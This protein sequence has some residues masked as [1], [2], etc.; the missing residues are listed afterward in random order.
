MHVRPPS[1]VYVKPAKDRFD[2]VFQLVRGAEGRSVSRR[3]ASGF[4]LDL[5]AVFCKGIAS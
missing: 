2:G 5:D 4:Q 3:V 1:H